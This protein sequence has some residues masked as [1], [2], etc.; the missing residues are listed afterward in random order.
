MTYYYYKDKKGKWRWRLRAANGRII[1]DSGKGYKSR[2]DCLED[3]ERIKSSSNAQVLVEVGFGGGTPDA[4]TPITAGGDDACGS[5]T[6]TPL[7][8]G[9]DEIIAYAPIT[10][11]GEEVAGHASGTPITSGGDSTARGPHGSGDEP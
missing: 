9:G 5:A 6:G 8:A 7:T 10:D 1:A 4:G 2:R 3:I 11:G